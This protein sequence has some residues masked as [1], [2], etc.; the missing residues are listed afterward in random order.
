MKTLACRD[1]TQKS[2]SFIYVVMVTVEEFLKKNKTK[3]TTKYGAQGK[4][5]IVNQC[6]MANI[7][8]LK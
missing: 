2:M 8:R 7:W 1:M 6:L 5:S 4:T 3:T